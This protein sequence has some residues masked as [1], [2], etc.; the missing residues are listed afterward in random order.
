MTGINGLFTS[1]RFLTLLF[2]TVVGLLVYFVGKYAGAAVE[3]LKFVILA[4]QPIV[5]L[6]IIAFT[7]NDMQTASLSNQLRSLELTL[8]A[9]TETAK[10]NAMAMQAATS[11]PR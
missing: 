11:L 5:G 6:V 1:R 7:V 10:Y 3:D 2:D 4:V 9:Q 8:S